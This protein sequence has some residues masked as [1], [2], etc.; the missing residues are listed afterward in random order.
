[1][2]HAERI[3]HAADRRV[4]R[5]GAFREAASGGQGDNLRRRIA[6]V[7]FALAEPRAPYWS[8][9]RPI[10]GSEETLNVNTKY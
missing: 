7:P 5:A 2:T 4:G 1:M 10:A 8:P 3:A 6:G 9:D